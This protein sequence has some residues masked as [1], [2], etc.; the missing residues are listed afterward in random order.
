MKKIEVLGTGCA[1]C[2]K[3]YEN[4]RQAANELKLECS[5]EKVTELP[6]IMSYGV[7]L[8]PAL[9]IDG[10]VAAAGRVPDP[11]AIKVMLG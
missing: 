2:V 9:V 10:K 3:L 4:V 8:T 11:A 6:K 5:I 1:K 7:M